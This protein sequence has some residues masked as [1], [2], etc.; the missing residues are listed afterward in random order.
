MAEKRVD[1]C[2]AK[3]AIY[4]AFVEGKLEAPNRRMRIFDRERFGVF[5]MLSRQ[6]SKKLTRFRNLGQRRSWEGS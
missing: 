4:E 6:P 2:Y 3:V 1:R 5:Q